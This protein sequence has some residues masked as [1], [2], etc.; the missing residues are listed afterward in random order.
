MGKKLYVGNL[1]WSIDDGKLG[2]LF[3][4]YGQVESASVITDKFSGKSRGFGFVEMAADDDAA[5]AVEEMHEK[6]IDGRKL[7]VNEARPRESRRRPR[8]RSPLPGIDPGSR[9]EPPPGDWPGSTRKPARSPGPYPARRRNRPDRCCQKAPPAGASVSRPP[10][11]RR[12][13]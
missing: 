12:P 11:P 2:G 8:V 4:D 3:S 10:C 13:R 5:K 6:E 9:P 1:P 7:T